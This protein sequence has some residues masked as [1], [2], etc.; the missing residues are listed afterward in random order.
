M[1]MMISNL[2]CLLFLKA[3]NRDENFRL[4]NSDA[5]VTYHHHF[6]GTASKELCE[7]VAAVTRARKRSERQVSSSPWTAGHR[8]LDSLPRRFLSKLTVREGS[9]KVVILV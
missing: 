5:D 8:G 2:L 6:C 7:H 1:M 4:V 3:F 9:R